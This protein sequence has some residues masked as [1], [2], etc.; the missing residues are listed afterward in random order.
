C[1]GRPDGAVADAAPEQERRVAAATGLDEG[2]V[3]LADV[4][5]EIHAHR[6]AEL[7]IVP[8]EAG[9]AGV[10]AVEPPGPEHRR[11]RGR[12][13]LDALERE[14]AGGERAREER[15]VAARE[16]LAQPLRRE[17]VDLQQNRAAASGL[18][19][20][21]RLSATSELHQRTQDLS[22]PEETHWITSGA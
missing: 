17:P 6:A 8:A 3:D 19:R 16:R 11:R 10:A 1:A 15:H 22:G 14:G 9:H 4:L 2:L 12:G 13:R 5:G 20:S 21:G 18:H 7:A